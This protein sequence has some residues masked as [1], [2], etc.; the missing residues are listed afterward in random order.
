MKKG[1]I[2]ALALVG[3]ITFMGAGYAAWQDSVTIESQVNT[4]S[5]DV[6]FCD[7]DDLPDV[8][9]DPA[10][11]YVTLE[12]DGTVRD[13]ANGVD[14]LLTINAANFYPSKD[15]TGEK[16][17]GKD[18]RNERPAL[19]ITAGIINAGSIPAKING[20]EIFPNTNANMDLYNKIRVEK[21]VLCKVY[22][23]DY[24]VWKLFKGWKKIDSDFTKGF[25]TVENISQYCP[26]DDMTLEEFETFLNNAVGD[27]YVLGEETTVFFGCLDSE[28]IVGESIKLVPHLRLYI[29]QSAG[30]ET[31][32]KNCTVNIKFNWKQF[33]K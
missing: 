22:K 31:Q 16:W 29:H 8:S 10:N 1:K 4:G 28:A 18:D 32:D 26:K 19:G 5:L 17:H 21:G 24:Y 27:D 13:D 14:K 7:N 30:N 11:S 3:A 9:I 20:V 23:G 25:D 6:R 12:D 15:V 33:N 2:I